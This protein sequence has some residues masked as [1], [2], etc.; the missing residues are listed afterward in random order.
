MSS[1]SKF[2]KDTTRRRYWAGSSRMKSGPA[3]LLK[4]E[5]SAEL[6]NAVAAH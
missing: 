6:E 5:L 1:L 2:M 3:K 4:V